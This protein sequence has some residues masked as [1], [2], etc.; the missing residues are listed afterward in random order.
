MLKTVTN[1]VPVYPPFELACDDPP[2]LPI[3]MTGG[4]VAEFILR[5]EASGNDCRAELARAKSWVD[6]QKLMQDH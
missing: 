3:A 5:S 6:E 4:E 2:S 1:R